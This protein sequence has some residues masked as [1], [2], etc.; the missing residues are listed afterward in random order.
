MEKEEARQ[1]INGYL[2]G[3]G[4]DLENAS[5]SFS[6]LTEIDVRGANLKNATIAYCKSRF[7]NF[8][9]AILDQT[10]FIFSNLEFSDFTDIQGE[11]IFLNSNTDGVIR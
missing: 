3:P 5:L 11:P 4:A 8:R 1:M 6:D 9:G 10:R 7:A 2:V